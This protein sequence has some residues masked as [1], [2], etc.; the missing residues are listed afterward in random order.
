MITK[1][2]MLYTYKLLVMFS[3]EYNKTNQG[4]HHDTQGSCDHSKSSTDAATR[5]VICL[6]EKNKIDTCIIFPH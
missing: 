3:L 1:N 6:A 4:S 5:L 2:D